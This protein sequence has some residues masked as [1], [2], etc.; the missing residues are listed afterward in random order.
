LYNLSEIMDGRLDEV[1]EQLK[2]ADRTDR[3][4]EGIEGKATA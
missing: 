1:V 2:L 3:L 4:Q